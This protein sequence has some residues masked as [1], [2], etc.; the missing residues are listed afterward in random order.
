M[1]AEPGTGQAGSALSPT[2]LGVVPWQNT[3]PWGQ[4]T[5]MKS[6]APRRLGGMF[7]AWGLAPSLEVSLCS[8]SAQS[9]VQQDTSLFPSLGLSFSIYKQG[10][11]LDQ[12]LSTGVAI[13]TPHAH[14]P[15]KPPVETAPSV[16]AWQK[17]LGDSGTAF[18]PSISPTRY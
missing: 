4:A 18:C 10:V 5:G 8:D 11:A 15:Q 13:R 1:W 16:Q 12:W 3:L 14:S 9:A 2:A 6:E 7:P 17:C